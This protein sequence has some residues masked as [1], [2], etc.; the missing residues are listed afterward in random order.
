VNERNGNGGERFALIVTNLL[1][2]G[3][4]A[5]AFIEA[6][7]RDELRPGVLGLCALLIAGV[8]GLETFIRGLFGK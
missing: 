8:Q 6:T 4:M 7:G 5:L 3:G 2:L 1:K